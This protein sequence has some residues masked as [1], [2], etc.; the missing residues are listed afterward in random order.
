MYRN[1]MSLDIRVK[2]STCTVTLAIDPSEEDEDAHLNR[3]GEV[4]HLQSQQ[5]FLPSHPGT[6]LINIYW[7]IRCALCSNGSTRVRLLSSIAV[8]ILMSTVC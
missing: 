5:T 8:A 3:V 1:A 6:E 2:L 7:S 4:R